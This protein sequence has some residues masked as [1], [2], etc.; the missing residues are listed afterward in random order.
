VDSLVLRPVSV[1]QIS[2]ASRDSRNDSLFRLDWIEATDMTVPEVCTRDRWAVLGTDAFGLTTTEPAL[3][4]HVDA[5]SL[6]AA[7][8]SGTPVPHE[9]FLACT[10]DPD[11]GPAA[12]RRATT[13]MLSLIQAW[14]GDERF[15]GSR[16]VVL[17]S[18]AV[19][20]GAGESVDDLAGA[21]VWGLLRSA[22]SENPGRFA[23]IDL[24]GHTA[25]GETALTALSTVL[26][27]DEPQTI[28]RNGVVRVPRL[29]RVTEGVGAGPEFATEG[30]V[31]VTGASGTLGGLFARHLVVEHG[32]R[33]LLL[34]SRRGGAAP[35]AS[36]LAA[37]LSG[38]GAEVVWA[39]CDVADREALAGVLASVPA[40]RPLTGVVHTA[41]VLDDGIIGSLTPERID[42]VMR[43]K[44][45]AAWNLHELTEGLDLSAFVLFS[46]AAGVFGNAGQANYAAANAF[47]DALAG[48]RRARGLAGSSLAWGLWAG[49]SA[50]MAG[51]LGEAGASRLGRGGAGAFG[52]AEGLEL[53][54][55]AGR[56]SEPVL[57]PIRL[58]ITALRAQAATSGIVPPLLRALVRVPGRRA[59]DQGA[60]ATSGALA[61]RLA[62]LSEAEQQGVLLELVSTQ[63]ATVL[64]HD[65]T[66]SVEPHHSFRELGFDSLTA[67]EL[68]NLLGGAT[69]L[70]LPA[71]LV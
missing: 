17:T 16:L 66:D 23:L 14:L 9:V 39:A 1:E 12:V 43:P 7:I 57:V 6:A 49:E 47:L 61:Q 62:G 60:A 27:S 56:S 22:Q 64:G 31:L 34:L 11:G 70:R 20:A 13:E 25:S 41:G 46:S 48:H 2:S 68:R 71:T 36:E 44:V 58:D 24:D 52:A 54:D 69:E 4:V 3:P 33:R 15:A 26:A 10:A 55:A 53:F 8:E 35:G 51:E 59:A 19:A 63:V 28:V 42:R 5:T 65:A 21:A 40:E 45:D 37:E 18:G 50:G 30:T 67:V 38:L 29:M 32:V